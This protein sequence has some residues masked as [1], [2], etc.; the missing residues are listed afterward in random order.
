MARIKYDVSHGK[1]KWIVEKDGKLIVRKNGEYATFERK[2]DAVD[3]AREKARNSGYG[4]L[5]IRKKNGE[6]VRTHKYGSNPTP[7][8]R[9]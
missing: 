9:R 5:R 1:D 3:F 4:K 6:V 8:Q 2:Q 7:K